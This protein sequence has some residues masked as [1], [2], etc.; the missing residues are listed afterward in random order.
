MS[1]PSIALSVLQSL[2][3]ELITHMPAKL[4]AF[5]GGS[6]KWYFSDTYV[7]P[8]MCPCI[9]IVERGMQ[10]TDETMRGGGLSGVTTGGMVWRTMAAEVA[11]WLRA[12]G[13]TDEDLRARLMAWC[14]AVTAIMDASFQLDQA[15]LIA[16]T[17]GMNPPETMRA[18]QIWFGCRTVR[19]N[20]DVFTT[21]GSVA[22]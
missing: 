12:G 4:P 1:D 8:A 5:D 14:G 16:S 19:V 11:V 18:G 20:V 10:K 21:Q 7:E 22:L 13:T 17:P 9:C 2:K 3:D 6:V 15:T